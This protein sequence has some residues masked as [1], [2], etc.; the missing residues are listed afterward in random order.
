MMKLSI[1]VFTL[2]L[3][4]ASWADAIRLSAPVASTE[5]YEVFGKV[6]EQPGQLLQL[7]ELMQ[8]ADSKAGSDV[9]VQTEVTEVCQKKGCFFTAVYG[10]KLIRVKFEGYSFFVPTDIASKTVKLYGRF[11]KTVV[12]IAQAKHYAKDAGLDPVTIVSDQ[13]EYSIVAKSVIVP[14]S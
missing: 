11:D 1:F 4:N 3:A 13:V 6:L 14:L 10:E 8:S 9:F 2:L 5:H 12:P 7:S